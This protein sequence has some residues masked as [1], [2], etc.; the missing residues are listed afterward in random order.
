M[1]PAYHN[2]LWF[3]LAGILI[4]LFLEVKTVGKLAVILEVVAVA[5]LGAS[6]AFSAGRWTWIFGLTAMAVPIVGAMVALGAL[7][8]SRIRSALGRSAEK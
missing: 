1:D 5:G 3:L 4:G 2:W 7:L 6:A 8:S